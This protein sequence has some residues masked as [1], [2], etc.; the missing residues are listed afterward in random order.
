MKKC[1][2]CK[3]KFEPKYSSLEKYCSNIDCKVAWAMNVGKKKLELKE[4][5]KKEQFKDN[6]TNW[7]AELQVQINKI[8]RLIDKDLFCLARKKGGQMHAGHIFSRGSNQNIKYNLHNLHRQN[9]Q[10]NHFQ[11]DDGLL[12]EGLVNEY[13]Q[14][15]MDFI[16]ELRRTP[17]LKYTQLEYKEFTIKARAIVL[18]MQ[19]LNLN[20]SITNRLLIRNKI[21]LE[22][23][24]YDN[25][26]CVFEKNG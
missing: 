6:V 23:G 1:V 3:E 19:K 25:E 2:V 22:L 4:K 21:N 5:E 11:N 12:R 18:R 7:K 20:Y 10:S 26:F 14:G 13:G 9:A 17:I 8:V 16:S 15:Y 24:I